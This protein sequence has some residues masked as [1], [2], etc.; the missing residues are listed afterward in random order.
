VLIVTGT[1]RSGTSMW[2]QILDAAGV[3]VI[4]EAFPKNW[5]TT[6]HDANPKGFYESSLCRGI[7]FKTNPNPNTGAYLFPEQVRHHAVKVF[8]TGT[9]RSD[10]AF[11]HR[12]LGTIRPWDEYVYSLLK[13][14]AMSGNAEGLDSSRSGDS[15][16][17]FALEWWIF[18]LSLIRDVATRRYP[19][20]FQAYRS[21]LADPETVIP[22]VFEWMGL[23]LESEAIARACA[24]VEPKLHRSKKESIAVAKPDLP[25]GTLDTFDELYDTIARG[26]AMSAT[27][28]SKLN[29]TNRELMPLLLHYQSLASEQMLQIINR[30]HADASAS[31]PPPS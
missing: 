22:K 17:P 12:V 31:P 9:V 10:V 23:E 20:H 1:P 19:F 18:N 3:P 21:L 8:I 2:M 27:F 6:I 7:N 13:L 11:L 24:V 5:A 25:P 26:D 14:R 15:K 16:M 28:I 4:G 30:A 29:D